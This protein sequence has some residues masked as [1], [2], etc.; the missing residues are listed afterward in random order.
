MCSWKGLRDAERTQKRAE[1]LGTI[2]WTAI[3]VKNQRFHRAA[4]FISHL[5]GASDRLCTVDLSDSISH[6]H[7]WEQIQNCADVIIPIIKPE[8][9]HV[10]YPYFIW[11]CNSIILRQR[12][13]ISYGRAV[14]HI[15]QRYIIKKPYGFR[16]VLKKR[17]IS[18]PGGL[19]IGS[20]ESVDI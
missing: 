7:S 13:N 17:K 12:S 9:G 10:A 15:A 6:V 5:K 2:I 14:F 4:F 3:S 19:D 20:P 18:F 1:C 11:T 8:A 16:S